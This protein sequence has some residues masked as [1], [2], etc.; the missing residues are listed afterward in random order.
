MKLME[1]MEDF[2]KTFAP[3]HFNEDGKQ[4]EDK[5]RHSA[6]APSSILL[7]HESGANV[8]DSTALLSKA[9]LPISLTVAG[10][11]LSVFAKAY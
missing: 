10:I 2:S 8:T 11:S 6:N 7:R 3:K 5:L 9:D 1:F 4:I